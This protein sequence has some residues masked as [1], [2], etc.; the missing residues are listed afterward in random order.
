VNLPTPAEYPLVIKLDGLAQGK[1]VWICYTKEEA[2]K[3]LEGIESG[4]L[5]PKDYKQLK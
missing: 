3:I 2:L 5:V 1:G 4:E